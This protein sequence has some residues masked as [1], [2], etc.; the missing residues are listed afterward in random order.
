MVATLPA[1][2]T[3][4][5]LAVP[6]R[7]S[8]ALKP[9]G[10]A[11]LVVLVL[12]FL[13]L[14]PL[15]AMP[16]VGFLAVIFARQGHPGNVVRIPE[17]IRLGAFSG[18]LSFGLTVLIIAFASTMPDLRA[19]L[20]DGILAN[21]E[22]WA[23]ARPSDAQIQAAI[24]QLKTPDGFMAAMIVGGVMLFVISIVLGAFGGIAGATI[25]GRKR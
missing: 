20:H 13:G 16:S 6:I 8:Q 18:L 24:E 25:F 9:C 12:M 2:E 23:A 17:A 22:K 10:L 1:T 7:W 4:P 21:A 5:V 11:A 19:K 3:V 14:N 15:V